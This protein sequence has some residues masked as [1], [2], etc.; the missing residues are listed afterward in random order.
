MSDTA[1]P[2][3]SAPSPAPVHD[4]QTRSVDSRS[5]RS[6]DHEGCGGGRP[7]SEST[8][9]WPPVRPWG[10]DRSGAYDVEDQRRKWRGWRRLVFPGIWLVYLGQ[11][12]AG[13]GK[14]SS[15]WAAVAGYAIIAAYCVCY[16]QAL[17]AL[18]MGRRRRFWTLYA[19]LLVL[20]AVETLFAH[21]DAFVMC[22]FI[23]VQTVG[24][25]GNRALPAIV[26]LTLVATLTPR[27]VTSWHADVQPTNG[28]TIPLT[29]LA[30]WGFFGVIRTNQALADARS[31]VARLAAENERAAVEI[32]EVEQ[33]S[34]RSLAEVRAA[35]AG[36]REVTL[37][38]EIATAREVL[39]AAG[40][41]AELPGSVDIVDAALS[42]LFGWVT[43]EGVT[44][45]VRHARATHC[46]I[47]VDRNSI[48]IADDGR[49]GGIAGSGNGLTG[50]RERVE[51]AG[52]TVR[53]E[54]APFKGWR[55]RV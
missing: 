45:V 41:V 34:R 21:E 1:S 4:Q 49:G 22:L 19:A 40:V 27:L 28:L 17:P 9:D 39:R 16:L 44:N 52:G 29:A 35:V 53:L 23:A 48:E 20:C 2:D 5:N 54:T 31:E 15:G 6:V 13:V 37:A 11:T 43:R 7:V 24:V 10:W 12:A 42:E 26:A 38:G 25:L 14:H 55:L 47:R 33:L 8:R 51:A 32:A 30:M 36:H 50:L 46:T 3:R 18:W